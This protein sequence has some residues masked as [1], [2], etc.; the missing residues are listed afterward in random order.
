VSLP[1][2]TETLSPRPKFRIWNIIRG[3]C[4]WV[5]LTIGGWPLLA[6]DYVRPLQYDVVVQDAALRIWPL[7][8]AAT[9][10]TVATSLGYWI[11]WSSN[12]LSRLHALFAA[13][14]P[15]ALL[16]SVGR[17]AGASAVLI[18]CATFSLLFLCLLCWLL[19]AR[20]S[21]SGLPKF[22][23]S[24]WA[25]VVAAAFL[26]A[27]L[28]IASLL[29]P[30]GFPKQIGSLA[31]LT[32]FSGFCA[33]LSSFGTQRPKVAGAGI[34]Y[35]LLAALL[36]PAND[37]HIPRTISKTDPKSLDGTFLDWLMNR[38]DLKKYRESQLPYPVILVSSEGGGIY[39]TAHAY[40]ALSLI[41]ANC[42]T[43]SQHV[44]A[45]VGISGGALGNALFASEMQVD[46][47][48]QAPCQP[49]TDLP[50][51]F[52]V[53]QDHLSPVLA[54]LL[55]IELIDRLVPGHWFVRDRAQVLADSFLSVARDKTF[56]QSPERDSFDT[57]SARPAVV[58]VAT[59]VADGRRFIMSPFAPDRVVGTG[60]WWPGVDNHTGQ[61]AQKEDITVI[62]GA[63][64]AARF[65]WITPT[66][67]VSGP[68]GKEFLLADGGYFENSGAD[69]V[70]DI[71]NHLRYTS[72][73]FRSL[74]RQGEAADD[75]Y[76]GPNC[77]GSI[78]ANIVSD[79]HTKVEWG[80]CEI[81]VFLIHFAIASSDAAPDEYASF[82]L[83]P[84][85]AF[86]G[87]QS[88]LLDPVSALLATRTSRADIALS[89]ADLELC[90]TKL[91]GADCFSNPDGSF[92]FF[93]NDV[94]PTEWKLPLGW[95][96]PTAMYDALQSSAIDREVF[97]YRVR[98]KE[99]T[100]DLEY[101]IFHLDPDLYRDGSSPYIN[102]LLGSP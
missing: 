101:L 97:N 69:T 1:L 21:P 85:T 30:I 18:A 2:R 3:P 48:E 59:N 66:G 99:A 94:R 100:N 44:F 98:K 27:S 9:I 95:F 78:I 42:P 43:F 63:G 81:R 20:W 7:V 76:N 19:L 62:D 86:A 74:N 93:R 47:K 29:D 50:R 8:I 33:A 58:S 23:A 65:P 82:G 57:T 26:Y 92:G 90:G 12:G 96:L 54:R 45:L 80:K 72:A 68:E 34:V 35:M 77:S 55:F 56:L 88:F 46:Q 71:I 51:A 84:M 4:V 40:G 64:A 11:L 79:F 28:A 41:A 61:P 6:L 102:D 37:H 39:A 32:A 15:L 67:L 70:L 25:G 17:I 60:Q 31:I 24:P 87:Y 89:R 73:F 75:P 49:S 36:L 10:A 22:V 53:V 14:L 91:S 5:V 83:Q 16:A 38:K 52:P 13:A